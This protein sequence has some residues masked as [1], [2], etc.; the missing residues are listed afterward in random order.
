MNMQWIDWAIVV[1]LYVV[2]IVVGL[3][4][5]KYMRGVA[6]FLVA[7]RGM[8]RYLGLT[9]GSAADMG[10]ISVVAAM[11]A[12][13]RAGPSIL[14]IGLITL[15]WGVFVG[16]TGFVIKRYRETRI[17]TMPQLFEMRYSKGVRILAGAICAFSG[18]L[19]M[20]IFMVSCYRMNA[21]NGKAN[22][23]T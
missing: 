9:A 18:I 23:Y 19:N 20:G 17:M 11:E 13:Y 1:A 12:M 2:L 10:A 21:V 3:Y 8:R 4:S 16:K 7:G 22:S 5:R 14:L 6:D 15:A